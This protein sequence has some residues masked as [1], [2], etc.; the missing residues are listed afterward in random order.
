MRAAY[1]EANGAAADVLRVAD[2][3]TP[4]PG[5]GEVRIKMMTS[6]VNPSDV[7]TRAGLTRKIVFP[8]VIPHSDGAGQ[9]D[10]VG[11]GVSATRVGERVWT[12]NGQWKRPF[13]TAAE[14]VVL[15]QQQAVALPRSVSFEVGAGIGIPAMTAWYALTCAE[16]T[17]NTTVFIPGGAGAVGFYAIQMAKIRGARVIT[18][19]SSEAKAKVAADAGAHHVI[20][21]K[22]EDVAARIGEITGKRGVD[23]ILE[24]DLGAGA[25]LWPAILRP[26]GRA[27]VYGTSAPEHLIP[28]GYCL[29]SN[30]DVRFI[31]VYE[32]PAPLITQ[33]LAD[34]TKMLGE[35]RLTH[36]IALT[37][38][39]N[40]I[41]AAHQAVEKGATGKV[42]VSI[43]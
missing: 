36:N 20:D 17:N 2:V 37:V 15:P 14:Y 3:P 40:D 28:A 19:V 8:R 30:I 18:T 11:D 27:V 35:N 13:G 43:T 39:L 21:Y 16:A 12:W 34:I 26:H 38:P 32:M 33:A 6:G 25:K 5:P 7:K 4:E 22:R 24:V 42:V 31:L 1:Y 10:K 9:I 29:T 41:V 23:A